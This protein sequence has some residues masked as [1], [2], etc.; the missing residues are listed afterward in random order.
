MREW[1]QEL[2]EQL[3]P[4]LVARTEDG[5]EAWVESDFDP[6]AGALGL[7]WKDLENR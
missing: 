5:Q 6:Q 1:Q 2:T 3:Q 7:Q 4:G